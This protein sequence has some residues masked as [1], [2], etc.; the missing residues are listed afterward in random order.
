MSAADSMLPAAAREGN[1]FAPTPASRFG[2]VEQRVTQ[3]SEWLNPILV[4]ETRQALKSRQFLIT[5]ILLLI[6]G[7]GWS[8]LYLAIQYSQIGE[9]IFYAPQ[10]APMLTGYY[11]VLSFPL[12][13]IVPF[14]AFRSLS[15]EREDGT[16]ELV[17]ITT[18]KPRQVIGGKLGSAVLQMLVYL[19]ALTPGMAFTYMLRG[20][21]I[22]LILMTC[23]YLFLTSVFFAVV[24]LLLATVTTSRHWQM[25]LGIIF[26]LG[27]VILFIYAGA[28][29]TMAINAGVLPYDQP[30]FWAVQA[31]I[32]CIYAGYISLIYLSAMARITF[33]SDNRSTKLRV[34][35]LACNVIAMGW[36]LWLWLRF[37]EGETL[38]VLLSWAAVHWWFMGSLMVGEVS[39][40]S[41]RVRR[42]LPSTF[43]GRM[44]LTW[45]VPGPGTGFMFAVVNMLAV[46]L[47]VVMAAWFS[48]TFSL[49]AN[50]GEEQVLYA[51][52]ML[53]YVVIYVGIVRLAMLLVDRMISGGIFVSALLG[54]VML[55]AGT[56]VPLALQALQA[57]Y[58]RQRFDTYTALL[59][60][61]PFCALWGIEANELWNIPLPGGWNLPLE[62][63]LLTAVASLVMFVNMLL[64]AREVERER[65]AIPVRV[66]EDEKELH[67]PRQLKPEPASPW[68][69]ADEQA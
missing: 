9:G 59:A 18:L 34:A 7:W 53:T 31:F 68:E 8:L 37:E 5:F 21:D 36:G 58:F 66:V 46:S 22:F 13:V 41:P 1:P 63:L 40:L 61:A 10:G 54:I 33:A 48:N 19:S 14:T 2:W 27:L 47:V 44:L 30:D 32:V 45:F 28:G 20:V 15:A 23:F 65:I 29:T 16:F 24:G 25:V 57:G 12:L 56:F 67:P 17:A 51:G 6:C 3:V 60:P 55:L 62:L 11:W 26:I 64:A 52:F 39:E 38:Y 4:K 50:V 69:L 35:M 49:Q 43:L 42:E